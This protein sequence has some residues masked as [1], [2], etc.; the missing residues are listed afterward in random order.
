MTLCANYVM[1]IVA[2]KILINIILEK[3]MEKKKVV[4]IYVALI[5]LVSIS[6]IMG[7]IAGRHDERMSIYEQIVVHEYTPEQIECLER[8][9]MTEMN[10]E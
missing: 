6:N 3:N 2:S 5:L 1:V 8:I 10:N 9:V 4:K 7:Y